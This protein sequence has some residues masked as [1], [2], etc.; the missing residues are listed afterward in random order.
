MSLIPFSARSERRAVSIHLPLKGQLFETVF[1][2]HQTLTRLKAVLWDLQ[3]ITRGRCSGSFT[4]VLMMGSEET[5]AGEQGAA[6]CSLQCPEGN[7]TLLNS[8][9]FADA[10]VTRTSSELQPLN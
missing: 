3:P 9:G 5:S 8:G 4:D 2:Q 6:A 1:N 10:V 7:T